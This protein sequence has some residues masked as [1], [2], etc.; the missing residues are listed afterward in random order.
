MNATSSRSLSRTRSLVKSLG[1]VGIAVALLGPIGCSGGGETALEA[2]ERVGRA[3]RSVVTAP[4]EA[5]A[6]SRDV[7][8]SGVTR[9]EQ[10]GTLAFESGGRLVARSVDLGDRVQPGSLIA[11]LDAKPLT[12]EAAVARARLA[13]LEARLAQAERDAVRT[14]E[15]AATGAATAEELEQDE[16]ASLTLI[17]SRDAARARL[18]QS[19]RSE[20][21]SRLT[22][23]FSGIVSEVFVEP[24]EVVA[25]GQPIVE[26]SGDGAVEVEV[27]LP[28]S[29]VTEVS[30][31]QEIPVVLPRLERGANE[32]VGTITS[33][34]PGR[35]SGR[36]FP[37]R[38]RLQP[39]GSLQ[40]GA[41]LQPGM[42]AQVILGARARGQLA[43]PLAA[44]VDSV[45][46]NPT[47]FRVDS[48]T[49]SDFTAEQIAVTVVGLVGDR[50]LLA[51]TADLAVGDAV[52]VAGQSGLAD[53]EIVRKA[54]AGSETS[55]GEGRP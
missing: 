40:A 48:G 7:H 34:S 37:M 39:G 1:P 9:A 4:V 2:G 5:V 28:E 12:H 32:V 45:G 36:L 38:V 35:G 14:R 8:L 52:I 3:V 33:I 18:A 44:V 10:R 11:R 53:G 27:E 23:S 19:E 50:A 21:E 46:E 41:S 54:A 25:A 30:V 49:G 43:V 17:G 24:G 20:R 31:G 29:L 15:L 13:E 22:A 6:G 51:E 55:L 16:A 26:I 42:T 47:L